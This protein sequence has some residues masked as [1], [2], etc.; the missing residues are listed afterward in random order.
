MLMN[1]L[2]SEV[3][4]YVLFKL[5]SLCLN[6][7]SLYEAFGFADKP[8]LIGFLLFQVIILIVLVHRC[9]RIIFIPYQLH[10]SNQ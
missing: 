6:M 5:F 1:L 2:V 4:V 9:R 3:H 10:D 7:G 8:V